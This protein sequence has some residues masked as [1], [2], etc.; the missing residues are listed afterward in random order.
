MKTNPIIPIWLMAIICIGMLV[1]KRKGV[2]NFIRQIL[3]VSLLFT[4][5]LR[6]MVFSHEVEKLELNVD[7]L[8]VIDDSMSMLAEDFD[9]DGRRIDAVKETCEYI[10]DK[11]EGCRFSVISFGNYAYRLVP[12]TSDI[13]VVSSAINN[14]EGQ[15]KYV[16]QGTSL[17]LPYQTMLETLE[18]NY[19]KDGD[20]MQVVFFFSDGEITSK[21]EK[22]ASYEDAAEYIGTGA[23]LGFG[24]E[25]GGKMLVHSYAGDLS[26]P[27]YMQTRDKSGKMVDAISKIDEDNLQSIADD[28]GIG[29][30]HIEEATDA[31]DVVTD[32]SDAIDAYA[33]E[34]A[35]GTEGYIDIYYWFAIALAALLLYDLI[36]YKRKVKE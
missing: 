17:N 25:K 3:I 4:L 33:S 30:Y 10:M 8:F 7:V 21:N 13:N 6:I 16:A 29:Y 23:V 34:G 14:L 1:M 36:Y 27:F 19:D 15:T 28:M 11:M 20:R 31:R 12:Y 2:W 18:N 9:G 5:N 26:T 32:I 35:A 24:T 22:L